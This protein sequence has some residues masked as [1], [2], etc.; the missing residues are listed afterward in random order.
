MLKYTRMKLELLNDY[1]M[2]LMVEQGIRG[3]L[4]QAVKH[5]AK[6]NNSKTPDYDPSKPE[7]W[8][9]YQDCNNLYGWAMSQPMPYG[10]FRWYKG[11][12]PLA[13]LQSLSDTGNT[14]RI[15]EVD[16]SYPQEL[17]DEHNDLPFLPV[18]DVP[19]GSKETKLMAT[20]KPKQRYV[21]HYVNLK[22]AIA[23]GLQVDKVHRVLEFQQSAW[24]KPYIEL[25]TE[26]R[27]KAANAFEIAFFKLMNNAVFGKTM[28]NMRKRI[29]IELISSPER[30]SKLVNQP[31]FNDCIKY[32]ERLCAVIMD[33]KMVKFIK[34][35]YVGLAVLDISK[36]LMYKYFY[37][38]LKP[39]YGSAI[40]LVYMDTDSFIYLLRVGDFYQDLAGSP[41]LLVHVDA[42]SLPK[43]HPCYS[44]DRKKMPGLFSD[45]TSGLTLFE[46][47]ALRSKCYAFDME[48]S[49]L[50]KSK[51]IRGHVV[52]NHLSLD[53]YKRCLFKDDGDDG[54]DASKRAL[55]GENAR[56]VIGVIRGG[57]SPPTLSLPYTP[58]RQNV[59]IRSFEHEVRTLRTT[60]LALNRFD[61]KRYTLNNRIDTLAHGHYAIPPQEDL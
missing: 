24:L 40:E 16:V 34:P 18:N 41:D 5:Y 26:M 35:I 32:G 1:D 59:S 48:G 42:S 13:D 28:E 27:K 25:N 30:L 56:A 11:A 21:V 45:E 6:A 20:L 2:L 15:Y 29:R 39:H 33:T 19:P 58:Y 8:I 60:K 37:D 10:G 9:V 49:E 61:D 4:V 31:T 53:D 44:T 7:S 14:G 54:D 38:V 22:Q 23:H 57:E 12:D 43:D 51:G 36:T 50:I 55:A 52:R 17:H 3:G 47:A 46:I